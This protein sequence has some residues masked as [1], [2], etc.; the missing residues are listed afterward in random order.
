MIYIKQVLSLTVI[1]FKQYLRDWFSFFM[2][3]IVPIAL[4][5]FFLEFF[6]PEDAHAFVFPITISFLLFITALMSIGIAITDAKVKGVMK[7]YR[8]SPLHL[9]QYLVAQILDRGTVLFLTIL[10]IYLISRFGY[11]Y[12]IEGNV[13]IFLFSLVLAAAMLFSLGFLVAAMNKTIE[14]TAGTAGIIFLLNFILGGYILPLDRL[15]NFVE[16]L[17][18]YL[19]FLPVNEIITLSYFGE[20]DQSFWV[21]IAIVFAWF[22]LF[23]ITALGLLK[24]EVK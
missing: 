10:T 20:I 2:A 5:I 6:F 12:E 7:A 16:I 17:S 11:G 9:W 23:F 1:E 15:P 14:A 22:L 13:L 24:K 18:D 21:K 4:Y 3:I 19:P 8:S